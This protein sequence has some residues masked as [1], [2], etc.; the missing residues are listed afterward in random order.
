[1]LHM[2]DLADSFAEESGNALHNQLLI[3][4]A[5]VH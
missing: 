5:L 4:V 1:M 2:S 3:A